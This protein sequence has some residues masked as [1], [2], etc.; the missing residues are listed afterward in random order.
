MYPE[1]ILQQDHPYRPYYGRVTDRFS[2]QDHV[3]IRGC[4]EDTGSVQNQQAL[5]PKHLMTQSLQPLHGK[6]NKHSAIPD[7][8]G[9]QG[10][11]RSKSSIRDH[12]NLQLP[13]ILL[14]TYF[15]FSVYSV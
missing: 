11:Y 6:A 12:S 3:Y 2:I 1:T 5:L 4:I 8:H 7:F 13:N 9:L 15:L 14:R 10:V